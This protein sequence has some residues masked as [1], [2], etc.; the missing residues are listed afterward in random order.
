VCVCVCVCVH[1]C[2][3]MPADSFASLHRSQLI[4]CKVYLQDQTEERDRGE[5]REIEERDRGEIEGGARERRDR[6]EREG[7]REREK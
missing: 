1:E 3:S 7:E 4:R 2:T 6:G 5:R